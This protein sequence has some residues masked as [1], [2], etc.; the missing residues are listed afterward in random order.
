[1]PL[2]RYMRT[3]IALTLK[4]ASSDR[5]AHLS[6]PEIRQI[7]HGRTTFEVDFQV[8]DGEIGGRTSL[9]KGLPLFRKICAILRAVGRR[10]DVDDTRVLV[11]C[12]L[13]A[14]RVADVC[15]P[16][17]GV[18]GHDLRNR[19]QAGD[20]IGMPL[21]ADP[22]RAAWCRAAQISLVHVVLERAKEHVG[23]ALCDRNES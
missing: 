15:V 18:A 9:E 2:S 16:E 3:P 5:E 21:W 17:H 13:V 19:D 10:T 6:A 22:Q 7:R 20:E 12:V 14:D 4:S 11:A 1:V 8:H 23:Y